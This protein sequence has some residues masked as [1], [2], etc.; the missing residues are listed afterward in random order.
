MA[1]KVKSLVNVV[2]PERVISKDTQSL[3]DFL[4]TQY[5]ELAN[6]I[7]DQ[8]GLEGQKMYLLL[9]ANQAGDVDVHL[10]I[11]LSDSQGTIQ[12]RR[13]IKPTLEELYHDLIEFPEELQGKGL[14]KLVMQTSAAIVDKL[15]LKIVTLE[16]NLDLGAYAWL[17][18]GFWPHDNNLN[19]GKGLLDRMVSDS[20]LGTKLIDKWLTMTPKEARAFVLTE[21]FKE[22]KS[23]FLNQ[24]WSGSQS[25]ADFKNRF[26]K[27][28]KRIARTANEQIADALIRH[29]TYLL[30][31]S[32]YVRNRIN[33]LLS[34]TEQD[35]V[36]KIVARL[37]NARGGLTHP[38]EVRRM[39]AL[40]EQ[41]GTIRQD[42]WD[43]AS[44][45]LEDEM[46]KLALSE[47][48]SIGEIVTLSLPVI[49]DVVQPSARLLKTI[50]LARPFQGRILGDWAKD[51]AA[52]DIRRIHSAIQVGMV[53]GEDMN[54]IARRVVG[55]QALSY[56]DGVVSMTRAQVQSVTRTAVM[57]IANSSRQAWLSD[58][59]DIITQER[60]VA[61]LDS[62]TSAVCRANDGKLFELGKGP[63]PPL[64]FN[65]RSLRIAA[66]DGTLAGD[67]PA[68]PYTQSQLVDQY[69]NENGL[70]DSISSRDNLPF[71]TKTDF[72]KWSR[73]RIRELVGPVPAETTYQQW[74]QSQSVG[75]Q[76]DVLGSTKA[77]LFRDGGLKL[78]RF[79]NRQGD[80][81]TLSELATKERDAFVAAGLN[82]DEY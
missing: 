81:L 32:G 56:D 47:T 27:K 68:K 77:K 79:V 33:D 74:L 18:Q 45:F 64:H 57:S 69:V 75:F 60:F 65:C 36:D 7:S 1:T 9:S 16:A 23:A 22:Y 55:T 5:S 13:V 80:E 28:Q 71:G 19:S 63:V 39:Q 54:T 41:V 3:V 17:R 78:D 15:H 42:A 24:N 29:Q 66:I 62:R 58:N 43:K 30:R 37:A 31:Y 8:L 35:L 48:V 70:D 20:Q 40:Q 73:K 50:A 52:D 38:V 2:Y 82:P 4:V 51:L 26:L 34:T 67:R 10:R 46:P 49:I 25:G 21:G 6:S 76:D 72:D 44:S 12:L 53:Q 61:T 11:R 59:S 14:A